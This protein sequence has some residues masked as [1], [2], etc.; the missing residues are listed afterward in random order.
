MDDRL[1]TFLNRQQASGL[2]G[3]VGSEMR[4]AIR[5]SAALL[6]DALRTFA[7]ASSAVRDLTV[8]PRAGNRF[9][10]Q[11]KLAK[12]A[13]LPAINIT[14]TIERQ[15]NLPSDP[16]LVLHL[17][18]IGGMMRFAGPAAGAFGN[19]PPGVRMEGDRVF[20]DLRAVLASQ[21]QAEWL[22][23]VE[24]LDISSDEGAVILYV[25][26]RVR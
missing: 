24:Q 18:G 1:R 9:D 25:Q 7:P 16:T 11:V 23:H 8:A 20:V 22:E 17:T 4:A 14:A 21:H 3:L 12:P 5:V 10:V 2:A 6:A 26:A 13:F 15:P 19:L